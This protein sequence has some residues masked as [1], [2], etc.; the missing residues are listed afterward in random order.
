M[1]PL[2]TV[3]RPIFLFE[4][5][6]FGKPVPTFPGHALEALHIAAVRPPAQTAFGRKLAALTSRGTSGCSAITDKKSP[7]RCRDFD[8][9]EQLSLKSMLPRL[10]AVEMVVH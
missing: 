9:R 5:G 7:G 2:R 8:C 6:P 4:Q 3:I 10:A 1:T